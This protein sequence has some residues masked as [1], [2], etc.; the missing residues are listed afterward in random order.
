MKR[1]IDL[2]GLISYI[3]IGGVL[4]SIAVEVL[5]LGGYLLANGASQVEFTPRW[6]TGGRD[7]FTYAGDLLFSLTQGVTSV[8]LIAIGIVLLLMTPY[9]R[10]LAS[11]VY[12]GV[13][14]NPKYT[15]ISLFVLV[16]LTAS[17]TFH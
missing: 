14:R 8:N 1:K 11:V 7:F 6:Q 10:V 16:V 5:G 12:F 17:L 13:E 2:E 4:I 9:V 3:L 15:L